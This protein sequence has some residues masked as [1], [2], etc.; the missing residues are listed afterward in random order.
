M[1]YDYAC[2]VWKLLIFFS[3]FYTTNL[4]DLLYSLWMVMLRL[5]VTP[6][7]RLTHTI[8]LLSSTYGKDEERNKIFPETIDIRVLFCVAFVKKTS[9]PGR[10]KPWVLCCLS[11]V[12]VVL[13]GHLWYS[14]SSVRLSVFILLVSIWRWCRHCWLSACSFRLLHGNHPSYPS[15]IW[16][17]R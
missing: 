5:Y 3:Y 15:N 7:L 9:F 16:R 12:P 11:P 6:L 10:E 14:V 2:D 13:V 17:H 4:H 8:N 1:L